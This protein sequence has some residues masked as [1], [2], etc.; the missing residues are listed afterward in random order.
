MAEQT[1]DTTWDV[2]AASSKA[3]QAPVTNPTIATQLG[4][5]SIRA[6]T[7][8]PLD[9]AEIRTLLEAA[10]QAPTW[11]FYQQR[12]IIRVTDPDLRAAIGECSGQPYVGADRG[13]LFVFVVDLYRNWRIREDR[14]ISGEWFSTTQAFLTGVQDTLLAAQNM[15]VAAES[16]GLGTVYLGS[17]TRD[18]ARLIEVLGLPR[19]T[20]PLVGLIVGHPDQNP[21]HKPRLPLAV[22]TGRNGYPHHDDYAAVL[23]DYDEVVATYYDLRDT[24]RRVDAFTAQIAANPGRGGADVT[25]ALAALHA[26]GLALR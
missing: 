1:P 8:E 15:V 26:Q 5:R 11:A 7:D 6:Y 9:D 24:N 19:L 17:I 14:G 10:R 4:H 22:T 21:Q 20:Y 12:T 16:M 3:P 23:A 2:E 25:D 13:E 18:P